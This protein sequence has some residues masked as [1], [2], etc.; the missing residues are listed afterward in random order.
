M[1]LLSLSLINW[2]SESIIA[3]YLDDCRDR[4]LAAKTVTWY[5]YHL[6]RARDW[7]EN[8]PSTSLHA[9]GIL[10]PAQLTAYYSSTRN[11][12]TNTRRHMVAALRA[13][14]SWLGNFGLS[15]PAGC[16]NRPRKKKTLPQ[17]LP[18]Q[19][20]QRL[21]QVLETEPLR[22]R[23]LC[24]LILDTG[25]R[26][27]EC[28]HLRRDHLD[29][30]AGQLLVRDGKGG[31]D[32]ICFYSDTTASIL[33]RYISTHTQPAVF[34]AARRPYHPL[35]ADAIGR[36]LRRLAARHNFRRLGPH[37]LRRTSGTEYHAAGVDLDTIGDQF[38][39]EDL[40]T[41]RDYYARLADDRRRSIL[42]RAS[43]VEHALGNVHT[44]SAAI[45]VPNWPTR[46]LGD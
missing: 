5:Q 37:L 13:F 46:P 21:L 2:L 20:V 40:E 36:A 33:S 11:L 26:A 15:N 24:Y 23:A 22:E 27:N 10:D 14:G 18:P 43:P 42:R 32:R 19:E 45:P 16:L 28:A 4:E 29:L 8:Q 17:V 7:L 6:Q 3:A 30:D 35:S 1:I 25:L 12:S 9:L 41:T 44:L 31:K 34:V 38:G 39:H